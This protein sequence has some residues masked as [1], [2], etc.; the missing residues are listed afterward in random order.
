MVRADALTPEALIKA[1]EAGDFYASSGVTLKDVRYAPETKTLTVEIEP[2]GDE[3]YTT[4]FVGTPKDYA[5]GAGK[6]GATA[7]NPLTSD[8]V[9]VTFASVRGTRAAYR[10]TGRE[11][12]VRAL[13]TSDAA[14]PN[15]SLKG[16]KKQA[17]T[18]PVGWR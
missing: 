7:G 14:H 4:Q 1:M 5:G 11:L 18:Q 13:V 9:G 2:E 3:A 6:E 10:L 15:P 12:Y 17:W 8:Q 16:Q